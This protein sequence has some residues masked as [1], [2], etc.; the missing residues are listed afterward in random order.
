MA[1]YIIIKKLFK[2]KFLN[3][4]HNPVDLFPTT[5]P[6]THTTKIDAH[7]GHLDDGLMKVF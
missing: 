3:V 4:R 6:D 5:N 2:L 1:T 7:L